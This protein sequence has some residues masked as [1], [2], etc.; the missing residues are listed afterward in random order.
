MDVDQTA[1]DG[2]AFDD[3]EEAR[4][5]PQTTEWSY[6]DKTVFTCRKCRYTWTA[7]GESRPYSGP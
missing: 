5:N 4:E 7:A 1:V 2:W 3:L 6:V